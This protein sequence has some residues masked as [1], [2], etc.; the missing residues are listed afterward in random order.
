MTPYFSQAGQRLRL[1]SLTLGALNDTGW[2]TPRMQYA[3]HLDLEQL[4]DSSVN[5]AL[6]TS[7]CSAFQAR[8]PGAYYCS[9]SGLSPVSGSNSSNSSS[10]TSIRLSAPPAPPLQCYTP[11]TPASCETSPFSNGC[12]V[13]RP[14]AVPCTSTNFTTFIP[15]GTANQMAG[16]PGLLASS[17]FYQGLGAYYG[18]G[19]TCLTWSN[20]TGTQFSG[21]FYGPRCD[22][23]G[24]P[25][26]MAVVRGALV[27]IPCPPGE[28]AAWTVP[29][30]LKGLGLKDLSAIHSNLH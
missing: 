25:L 27:S 20:G 14:S 23:R 29:L 4:P 3:Q 13:L 5:C 28:G 17:S 26:I 18:V 15:Q 6:A 7:T 11:S 19:G 1:S 30:G 21:C 24:A 8:S 16:I 12:G 10:N 9:A 2:Y 22:A